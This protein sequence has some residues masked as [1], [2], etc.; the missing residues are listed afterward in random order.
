[1]PKPSQGNTTSTWS[2]LLAPIP[3]LNHLHLFNPPTFCPPLSAFT[4]PICAHL[5]QLPLLNHV[6]LA[7]IWPSFMLIYTCL[8]CWSHFGGSERGEQ[9]DGKR[10][11]CGRAIFGCVAVWQAEKMVIIYEKKN[12]IVMYL[13]IPMILWYGYMVCHGV[14][15]LTTIPIPTKPMTPNPWVF[16]YLSQSLVGTWLGA[17]V[18]NWEASVPILFEM[19]AS[20]SRAWHRHSL[21]PRNIVSY[22][23][24][25]SEHM[26]SHS[27]K[28]FLPYI[29]P[30]V[31]IHA[32][33]TGSTISQVI[34]VI[35]LGQFML[36]LINNM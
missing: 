29:S 12:Y 30:D 2:C 33:P 9:F 34:S 11:R 1:M 24:L 35:P 25:F 16:L 23:V 17:G 21:S 15:K 3:L 18:P 31:A 5:C 22:F 28:V 6:C 14:L 8:F 27:L 20:G 7:L 26:D 10:W 36:T 13:W 4:P 19:I 32:Y